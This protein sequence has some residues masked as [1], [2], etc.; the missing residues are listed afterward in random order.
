MVVAIF[1]CVCFIWPLLVHLLNLLRVSV[2][3]VYKA[4]LNHNLRWDHVPNFFVVRIND[5]SNG[6]F[7]KFLLYKADLQFDKRRLI[8][9]L[10]LI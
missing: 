1:P 6:I 2:P 8:I 5:R 4:E 10:K 9:N 7:G 3:L